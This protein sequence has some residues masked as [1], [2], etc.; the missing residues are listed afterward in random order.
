[1]TVFERIKA[2]FLRKR[3]W[4]W[5]VVGAVL[6]ALGH[7]LEAQKMEPQS[8]I[9]Q[10]QQLTQRLHDRLAALQ[11][12][13][14]ADL[15]RRAGANRH[16]IGWCGPTAA[17]AP[18]TLGSAPHLKR[19]L[20]SAAPAAPVRLL[21]P[22]ASSAIDDP[23]ANVMAPLERELG[24]PTPR[25]T[26][27][28]ATALREA[29][30]RHP[31]TQVDQAAGRI[32]DPLGPLRGARRLGDSLDLAAPAPALPPVKAPPSAP[33]QCTNGWSAMLDDAALNLR[34]TPEIAYVV[35][36]E[37]G[38]SA[39]ILLALTLAVIGTLIVT[40]WRQK[41]AGCA[42]FPATLLLLVTGPLIAQGLFWLMLQLLLGFTFVLGQV[43]AGLALLLAWVA[44]LSKL[45]MLAVETLNKTDEAEENFGSL[46]ASLGI[47]PPPP[48]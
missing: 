48:D 17:V 1:M 21:L 23:T 14:I 24:L 7:Y 26:L 42:V 44:S 31:A 25:P 33:S 47:E 15:Y 8:V 43:L 19:S 46:K 6:V 18:L 45:V 27:D 37:G 16:G 41:D 10:G 34:V 40:V 29:A 11:P 28:L 35:W 38:W 22:S 9:Q 20:P 5:L 4:R 3:R 30:R 32:V 13:A 39:T 36:N 12:G 2:F